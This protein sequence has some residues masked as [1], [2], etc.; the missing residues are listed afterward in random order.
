MLEFWMQEEC[1]DDFSRPSAFLQLARRQPELVG[2][3]W[4]GSR[5]RDPFLALPRVFCDRSRVCHH[6][7]SIARKLMRTCPSKS[8]FFSRISTESA[9]GWKF[10][11]SW[12]VPLNLLLLDLFSGSD[13]EQSL[14]GR[15][16]PSSRQIRHWQIRVPLPFLP[17]TWSFLGSHTAQGAILPGHLRSISWIDETFQSQ[18]DRAASE[19]SLPA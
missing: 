12:E 16:F 9:E 18:Q 8:P 6:S 19:K 4:E 3:G 14:L 7:C 5:E 2:E 1:E 17:H 11:V 15:L 10:S 13:E